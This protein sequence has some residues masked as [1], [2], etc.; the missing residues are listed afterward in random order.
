MSR[1]TLDKPDTL[2]YL[3]PNGFQFNIDTLP[4]VSFFCQ[5]AMIPA[6]TLSTAFLANPLV[7]FTVPG[8]NLTYDELTIKFI[9][10]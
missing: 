9:V 8:T 4:N 6:L 3:K 10:Q 5:S 2:N 7:D 1:R